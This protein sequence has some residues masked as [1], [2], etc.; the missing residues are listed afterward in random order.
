MLFP[1]QLKISR[2]LGKTLRQNRFRV[3]LDNA[4]EQV[5]DACAA[6]RRANPTGGTWI[7]QEMRAAYCALH[8]QGYAHSVE[9]W[10]GTELVGG[11]YGIALGGAF[12]GESMFS[13][14]TDASKVA[15]ARIIG[16]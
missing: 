7:T 2:S 8:A 5:I 15:L 13:R 6:P 10:S 1:P 3:T 4:F 14:V 16:Q 12:F 11:L 9:A